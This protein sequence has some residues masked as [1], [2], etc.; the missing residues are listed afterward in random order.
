LRLLASSSSSLLPLAGEVSPRTAEP[1]VPLSPPADPDPEFARNCLH[2]TLSSTTNEITSSRVSI[3]ILGFFA[4][5]APADEAAAFEFEAVE[6]PLL[7]TLFLLFALLLALLVPVF[8]LLLLRPPDD[9]LVMLLAGEADRLPLPLVTGVSFLRFS[10]TAF[11]AAPP[12]PFFRFILGG[13]R[14]GGDLCSRSASEL[15]ESSGRECLED[16]ISEACPLRVTPIPSLLPTDEGPLRLF[17]LFEFVFPFKDP[18][19][20]SDET[21]FPLFTVSLFVPVTVGVLVPRFN[22]RTGPG[23][24]DLSESTLLGGGCGGFTG[25]C[26]LCCCA[27][28]FGLLELAGGARGTGL[29]RCC[30]AVGKI[31]VTPGLL[32]VLLGLTDP[33]PDSVLAGTALGLVV[34]IV[35]AD[36]EFFM[37]LISGGG[38]GN[39]TSLSLSKP[40]GAEALFVVTKDAKL[41]EGEAFICS[42]F[43]FPLSWGGIIPAGF[44]TP[45]YATL[46]DS[47]FSEVVV[48]FH[49]H[50]RFAEQDYLGEV[51]AFAVSAGCSI[52]TLD[53]RLRSPDTCKQPSR[54]FPLPAI[55]Q[56]LCQIKNEEHTT[57]FNS[58][59]LYCEPGKHSAHNCTTCNPAIGQAEGYWV[60]Q[61]LKKRETS[62]ECREESSCHK[63]SEGQLK[64]F[65]KKIFTKQVFILP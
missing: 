43:T 23:L 36:E 65:L 7:L 39:I 17:P 21:L 45:R 12:P 51:L 25:V 5:F 35:L 9:K 52:F 33:S 61:F 1:F 22:G 50:H 30:C 62:V 57:G 11:L 55:V 27:V 13:F 3:P 2:R 38:L 20:W 60:F 56:I 34:T 6:V 10:S 59:V 63:G 26:V 49:L 32:H 28:R 14:L 8:V 4:P 64:D 24:L 31:A 18:T 53:K 48:V 54:D 15:D 40:I 37:S 46:L 58:L 42:C 16:G 29:F 47:N 41:D 19:F 44:L